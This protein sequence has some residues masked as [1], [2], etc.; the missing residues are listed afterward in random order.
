[1]TTPARSTSSNRPSL[2]EEM[3]TEARRP[4]GPP[5]GMAVILDQL[6]DQERAQL[7]E[8]LSDRSITAH[9]IATVLTNHGHRVA[10][11]TVGRHRGGRCACGTR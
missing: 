8:A 6:D 4:K 9:I 11:Q 5:C 1:M 2:L 7:E 3:R 10:L